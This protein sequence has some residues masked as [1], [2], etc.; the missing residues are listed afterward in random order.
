MGF[1]GKAPVSEKSQRK[2]A[3]SSFLTTS[4][5]TARK[6]ILGLHLNESLHTIGHGHV[7]GFCN[8]EYV[9]SRFRHKHVP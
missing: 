2:G 9:L 1:E 8:W 6:N 3:F 4:K 5:L 7:T